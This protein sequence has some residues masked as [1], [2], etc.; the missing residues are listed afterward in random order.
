M[1]R[2]SLELAD[3]FRLHG[4]AYR[5]A[6]D[7][8]LQQLRLMRAIETCRTAALGGHV[9]QC[10]QHDTCDH[11]RVSYNSCSNR[12]CPK[13]GNLA[14]AE[15]LEQR[16]AELL[17]IEYFHVV[18]TVPE[19]IAAI[20]F[21]NKKVVYDILF[22]ASAETLLTIA[23]DPKHLGAE[24]G[25]FSLLH[26]WGQNL[27]HH[28]HVHCVVSGGGLSVDYERWVACRPGFLLPVRVL[29]RLFRRLFLE[30]LAKAHNAGELYFFSELKGLCKPQAF[31]AYLAP[32]AKAEWVVYAKPPF[33]GALQVL[34]YLG[35]Y[36]QRVALS[37]QRLTALED[38]KVSFQWKDYRHHN[39]SKTMTLD[40]DEFIRRFLLHT[41]PPGFQR[42]RHYG[43]LA[44]CHRRDKIA[45]CRQILSAPVAD[46]WPS[47]E[48]VRDYRDLYEILSGESLRRCPRCGIGTMVRIY[49]LLP[50]YRKPLDSS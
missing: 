40:A 17:P 4:A 7:L 1:N 48:Q 35:R 14:R 46:L 26:T 41:L 45:L 20:A 25:F 19:E 10:D 33:G 23:G 27:L 12:H 50:H 11:I 13:C 6:H 21:Y 28:P 32:L 36:T 8:P 37:N 5:Q 43:F 39:R 2:P 42:I 16:K 47:P 34:E 22:R 30:A 31:A 3:I 24:V 29:S 44:N 15:W 49:Q 18:F 38:G 9:E